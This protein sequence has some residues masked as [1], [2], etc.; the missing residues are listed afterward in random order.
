M[1]QCFALL[2]L[3]K[4]FSKERV[5]ETCAL[6]L[7]SEMHDYW[8]LERMVKLAIRH[9]EPPPR[10]NNVV[11]LA[12]YLRPAHQYALPLASREQAVAPTNTKETKRDND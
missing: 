2:N 10:P 3:C 11:P 1:R 9:V 7:A 6:A 4:R 5:D 8:R 12:R